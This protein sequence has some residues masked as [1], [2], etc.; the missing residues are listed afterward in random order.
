[1]ESRST[2]RVT[3]AYLDAFVG[4]NVLIVGQVTQLRGESAVINADGDI[5]AKL[6]RVRVPSVCDAHVVPEAAA[7]GCSFMCTP[8]HVS[9]SDTLGISKQDA[10][11][12]AGN[13]AQLIG[14]VN[15]DRSVRVLNAVDLGPGVGMSL[16][17]PGDCPMTS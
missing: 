2:P 15:P 10:H 7:Q 14:K 17:G 16:V 11:L 1:M 8:R 13:A 9:N 12:I 3:A 5:D 4:Q 6:N